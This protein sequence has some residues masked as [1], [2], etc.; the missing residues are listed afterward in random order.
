MTPRH[1]G[2]VRRLRRAL[3]YRILEA[4]A[5]VRGEPPRAPPHQDLQCSRRRQCAIAV[6]V[7]VFV[8]C[9]NRAPRS[10]F[11]APDVH[12]CHL[13]ESQFLDVRYRLPL[14]AHHTMRHTTSCRSLSIWRP[15]VRCAF[16]IPASQGSSKER[17]MRLNPIR[18]CQAINDASIGGG[19][20][21]SVVTTATRAGG[22]EGSVDELAALCW[23][24]LVILARLRRRMSLRV[25]DRAPQYMRRSCQ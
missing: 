19:T 25:R 16:A 5:T 23:L 2:R 22:M 7:A 13:F 3:V 10:A 12:T 15:A 6:D 4:D 20:S 8:T 11:G 14:A 24:L 17:Y 9:R 18:K 21:R 1:V